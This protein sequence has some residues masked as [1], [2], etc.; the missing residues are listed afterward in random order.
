MIKVA[1]S[2]DWLVRFAGAESVLKE[3]LQIYKGK[4]YTLFYRREI[5]K[6]L[7]ITETEIQASFLNEL[8]LVE[9]YY[10]NLLP[11]FPIGISS[12]KVENVDILISSSHAVANGIRKDKDIFHISYCHTPMRYIW[13]HKDFYLQNL[14]SYKSFLLKGIIPILRKWDLQVSKNIDLFIA[15][16]TAVQERIKEIYNRNSIIIHP[17]VK[18]KELQKFFSPKKED[19]YIYVGRLDIPYKRVDLV[20]KAFNKLKKKLIVVGDGFDKEELQKLAG[21]NIKFVGWKSRTI[22]AKY[23]A[24]AKALILPSEEDFGIVAV[25]SQ[26]C[27][28]PVIAYAKGGVLDTVI[29]YKT[30]ILFRKQ[31]ENHLID[32]IEEFEK[33]SSSF[34]PNE[35]VK[36]ALKFDSHIFRENFRNLIS[37]CIN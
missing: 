11:L 15:T 19:Y 22:L 34:S 4:I 26:A 1:Y 14:P 32:A 16:S 33:I 13:T 17:P 28:T 3:M 12:L 6:E 29:P 7:G 18:V 2:H 37:S 36:N 20:I 10:R 25:E 24:K 31:E 27:G 23:L 35:I 21:K 30:G 9:K 8:P 5:L